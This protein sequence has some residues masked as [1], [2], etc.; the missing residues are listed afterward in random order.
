MLELALG[1]SVVAKGWSLYLGNLFTQFGGSLETTIS[2][3]PLDFD[4]GAVLIVAV[5]TWV[6]VLGTKLSARANMVITGI[7]VAVVLLVIIVGFFYFN[8]SNLSPFIPP[9]EPAT[10]AGTKSGLEQPLLQL[11]IGGAPSTLRRVS[12]C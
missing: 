2:L 5:I 12:G 1:A 7:K 8:A 6:L 4:W 3:G 10:E 11:I 9:S